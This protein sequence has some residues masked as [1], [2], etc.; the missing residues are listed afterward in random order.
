[1]KKTPEDLVTEIQELCAQLGWCVG[2]NE[3][4]SMIS[5]LIIG[6]QSFI[7]NIVDQITE[8]DE[9]SIYSSNK[10]PNEELN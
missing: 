9:F 8:G 6:N 3:N 5:G 4:K 10:S 1:M 2:M 7:T